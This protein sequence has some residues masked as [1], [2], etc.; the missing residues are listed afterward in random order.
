MMDSL[1]IHIYSLPTKRIRT[2]EYAIKWCFGCRKRLNHQW[3]K[4]CDI[5]DR[6]EPVWEL[7]CPLC[8]KDRTEF[9]S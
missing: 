4:L 8:G 3:V 5:Q 7:V 1:S 2:N 6:Y 9:G